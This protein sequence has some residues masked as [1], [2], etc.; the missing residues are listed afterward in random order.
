MSAKPAP[1][2]DAILAR[3]TRVLDPVDA[4]VS[5]PHYGDGDLNGAP[6][7]TGRKLRPAAVLALLVREEDVLRILFTRRADH[8]QAHAGQVSFPGGSQLA[9]MESLAEC[10]LRETHEEIG[11]APSNIS[12]IGRWES[13]ET[14]T[15]FEVTPFLG[16]AEAGFTLTPDPGEVAEV[17]ETPFDFLMNPANHRLEER[18]F[19]GMLRRYYAMPWQGRYIWGATAGMLRALSRRYAEGRPGGLQ[20]AGKAAR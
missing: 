1:G 2:A 5:A 7:P 8:L 10:A 12:L 3:L 20:F 15:G 17:F 18:E 4:R 19:R 11:L 16:V 14:V 6:S 9:G 13:Y